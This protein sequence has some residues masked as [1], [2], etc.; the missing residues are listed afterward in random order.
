MHY[1][2]I[3]IVKFMK[4]FHEVELATEIFLSQASFAPKHK[5]SGAEKLIKAIQDYKTLPPDIRSALESDKST[6]ASKLAELEKLCLQA[7]K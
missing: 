2:S 7:L 5:K 1:D 6:N 3:Q 4:I